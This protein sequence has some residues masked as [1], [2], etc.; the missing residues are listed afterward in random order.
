MFVICNG[1]PRSASTW[2]FRVVVELLQRQY[3]GEFIHKGYDPNL[4]QFT[5][6]APA[7]VR[8]VVMKSHPLTPLGRNLLRVGAVQVIYTWRDLADAMVSGLETFA[9]GGA[10]FETFLGSF[11]EALEVL[12]FH[13]R[14]G[15]ALEVNYADVMADARTQVERIALHLWPKGVATGVIDEASAAT[16]MDAAARAV[17]HVQAAADASLLETPYS[18]FHPE[19]L[20][21]RHHLNGGEQGKGRA[22]LSAEQLEALERL[23]EKHGFRDLTLA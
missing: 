13:R 1:M 9:R 2:S 15:L 6:S 14:E 23:R 5:K 18:R 12:A 4:V 16:S 10:T 19:T 7:A 22:R 21:H 17:E 20:F 8:H 11:D 3:P